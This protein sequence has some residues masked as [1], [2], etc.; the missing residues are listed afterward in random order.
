MGLSLM[1]MQDEIL[2]C[3]DRAR[4]RKAVLWFKHFHTSQGR[5]HQFTSAPWFCT[6]NTEVFAVFTRYWILSFVLKQ[7][8]LQPLHES[9][10][11]LKLFFKQ[12]SAKSL[13]LPWVLCFQVQIV[14]LLETAFLTLT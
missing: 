11:V 5:Y 1:A 10:K 12:S 9:W 2:H 4:A 7:D 13:E 8:Q 14:L 3:R 6:A